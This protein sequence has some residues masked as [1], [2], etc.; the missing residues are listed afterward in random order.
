MSSASNTSKV[1]QRPPILGP[2]AKK[3]KSKGKRRR[4]NGVAKSKSPKPDRS[5]LKE[6][7]EVAQLRTVLRL[8]QLTSAKALGLR[9]PSKPLEAGSM[10]TAQGQANRLR[11]AQIE[12]TKLRMVRAIQNG[13]SSFDAWIMT[14]LQDAIQ[15][16]QTVA[17]AGFSEDAG[18]ESGEMTQKNDYLT[19]F[20]VREKE[21]PHPWTYQNIDVD[22]T[23]RKL[24]ALVKQTPGPLS[25]D[26]LEEIE[27]LSLEDPAAFFQAWNRIGQNVG[28]NEPSR[29]RSGEKSQASAEDKSKE[30]AVADHNSRPL[31]MGFLDQIKKLT[32]EDPAAAAQQFLDVLDKIGQMKLEDE[33]EEEEEE[34]EL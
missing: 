27:L 19:G 17:F 5:H 18:E 29:E 4:S 28:S 13:L 6:Q 25:Q 20:N 31:D 14:K 32:L 2:R 34:E 30:L 22:K 10:D 12:L 23:K 11:Q 1:K 21:E 15:R 9:I 16:S 3:R 24:V 26:S 33:E 8:A 7:L